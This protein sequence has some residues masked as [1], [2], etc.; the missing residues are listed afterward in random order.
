VRLTLKKKKGKEKG[1]APFLVKEEKKKK[2]RKREERR[3]VFFTVF[4]IYGD[5]SFQSQN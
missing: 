4:Q 2:K 5:L 1:R 3:R